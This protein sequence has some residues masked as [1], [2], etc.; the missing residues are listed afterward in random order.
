[1]NLRETRHLK[2]GDFILFHKTQWTAKARYTW[3][4]KVKRV[5]ERGGVLVADLS[6]DG[7]VIGEMW[8]PYHYIERKVES[9]ER[10]RT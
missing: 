8:V 2:R 9:W 7:R 10:F 3:I 4:G 1:M 5:T 6:D